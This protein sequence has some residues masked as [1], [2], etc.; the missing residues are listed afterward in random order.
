MATKPTIYKLTLAVSDLNRDYYDT[1]NLTVALHPSETLERMM[2]RVVAYC[3]N[4]QEQMAFGKGI[5]AAEE[6]D[7]WLKSLDDQTLLW[8]DVGEPAPERIKKASRLAAE[9][10]VYSFN[11]KSTTWWEQNKSKLSIF[12]NVRCYQFDWLQIQALATLVER[13]MDWSL[14][15]SGDTLYIAAGTQGCEVAIKEL[16]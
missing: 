5:S 4:A 13:T 1:V 15:I 2:V 6:P 10:K 12:P 3:L 8:I 7:I 16:V 11:N 14:S 9:V